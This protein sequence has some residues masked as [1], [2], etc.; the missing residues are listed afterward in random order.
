MQFLK[1]REFRVAAPHQISQYETAF[2]LGEKNRCF[3]K[4]PSVF[5]RIIAHII[6]ELHTHNSNSIDV[7]HAKSR[8]PRPSADLFIVLGDI[9]KNHAD[10]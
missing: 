5:R 8:I 2:A 10:T 7:A 1:M 6:F 9:K 4:L 3:P